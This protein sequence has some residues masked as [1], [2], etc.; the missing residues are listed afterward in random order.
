MK[1]IFALSLSVL[2]CTVVFA[3]GTDNTSGASGVAVIKKD[4]DTYKLIY[5]AE[6]AGGVRVSILDSKNNL[7]F[8][9]SIKTEDGFIRPYNFSNLE[10]GEYTIQIEDGSG[11]RVEKI[12]NY[13]EKI[14]KFFYVRKL[15]S[16]NKVVLSVAG[17][18]SERFN[19]KV[20]DGSNALIYDEDKS[21][22]GNFAQVYNLNSLK[23][24]ITF[25]VTG[26]NGDSKTLH[27]L[28]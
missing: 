20:F 23:G 15:P 19:I 22:S 17:E 12:H 26:Q 5:K 10:K 16:E 6:K 18:G 13:A 11:K 9:E 28:K 1:K 7:V 8:Q 21:I 4:A 25:E 24:D 27:V 2:L 3:G 14:E